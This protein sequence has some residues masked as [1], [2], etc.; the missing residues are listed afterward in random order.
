MK[1][2]LLMMTAVCS[3][4]AAA[5]DTE[6]SVTLDE[7][8]VKGARTIQKVDG[9]WIY[10]TK[11]QIEHSANGYS[12][13]AKLT[14]PHIRVDE[15]QN[16]ITALTNLGTVQVR[17]NDVIASREDLQTLDMQGIDHIEFI[18]N[19]GVRYGEGIAYVINIKV[20]KPVS[21]YVVGTQLT[22]T[23]TTVNGN[24]SL[25]GKLNF[26]RSEFALSYDL[27]YHNF[28]G[29]DYDERADYELE[30]GDIASIHRY[31][32]NKQSKNISHNAQL[33]YS[34]SDSNYVFQAK[35][36]GN[37]DIQPQR[38]NALM[39]INDIPYD[40]YSSSRSSSPSLDLYFHQD[41]RRHQSLT[42]NVVGTYIKTTGDTENNEG[43][44]YRYD[45]DG[46][47]YSLWSEAIYENRLKPFTVSGGVQYGQRY[48]HNIY[49]GDVDA[50]ND[51]RTSSL[52]FFSQLKGRLGKLSYMG[53]LGVSGRYYRQGDATQDYWFF[54]P[55]FTV[56]YPLTNRLKMKYDFEIS[57]HTSQI[58]LVS[59]V[60]IK[61]NA[62]ETILGNP[63]IHPNRVISHQLKLSYST[64]RFTSELQG[65]Y[66]LNPHCN[67]EKY[68]RQDGHFYQ[69]QTN[70][71]NECNFFY[72]NTYNQWDIISEKLTATVYGGIYR[73]FNFGE[74]YTHTYTSFNGGC[75][76]QA[77]L[78]RWTLG[79]YADNGWNFMEG[80]HRGHQAPAWYITCNYRL[81][82][83]FSISLYAQ[84][85]LSQ[86]PL[87]NKTEV[88]SRYVQKEISQHSRDY[89]NMFTLKLS[90]RFDHGRKYRDIQR[91]MNHSD[92]ETGILSK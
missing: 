6:K 82:D 83:A 2:F 8:T 17:I 37:S 67:M 52:Y 54:R 43:A 46:R 13:L 78:G 24:E 53:G 79:A 68:I 28:K 74:D 20:K 71:D 9:Q 57:Q 59:N 90:Y 73:F 75:S 38:S 47:T 56:S 51:M 91:S 55:K 39:A 77:Y 66:R 48:S 89:G 19:P 22:N 30:S 21:G 86:H 4:T 36:S 64:S 41:F 70:A 31:S 69:T 33:T 88:V 3:L 29:A 50:I 35:F 10:P 65:Y 40:E 49:E 11:Q 42:A 7:V 12:L 87:T 1:R 16:A 61:Q 26:G 14:L 23:L 44:S 84:H 32:L 45:T 72:I 63:D 81:N 85:P 18:D 60:S 58:A 5:Q 15:A 25:Y 80:E 27:D 34:L 76:L 92:K 62:M